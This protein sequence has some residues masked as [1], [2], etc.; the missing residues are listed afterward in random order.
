MS[1]KL[2][3]DI[4]QKVHSLI[5]T[6]L[7]DDIVD[8]LIDSHEKTFEYLVDAYETHT[9]ESKKTCDE[10]V[11]SIVKAYDQSIKDLM[12]YIELPNDL[13]QQMWQHLDNEL[14][15]NVTRYDNKQTELNQYVKANV[16]NIIEK[17]L[18]FRN[19]LL[20]QYKS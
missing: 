8:P 2:S 20:K 9:E 10:L 17:Y 5:S 16:H 6:Y 13:R 19:K 4:E 7:Q 12:D 3:S 18:K 11:M 14:S 15:T 1:N